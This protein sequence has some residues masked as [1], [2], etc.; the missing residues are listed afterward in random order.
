M[1]NAVRERSR[2]LEL[3]LDVLQTFGK[4]IPE[5]GAR[6]LS[7][8]LG[9]SP[10]VIERTL[11]T[12]E[13]R[14][15]LERSTSRI[16]YRLGPAVLPLAETYARLNQFSA[17]ALRIMRDIRDD[18]GETTCLHI[19]SGGQRLTLLQVESRQELRWVVD[20]GKRYPLHRG[21]SG[22]VLLAY[23]PS[24]MRDAVLYE[25]F[26]AEWAQRAEPKELLGSLENIRARGWSVTY[27]ER[28]PGG[29]GIAVPVFTSAY[30]QTACLSVYAPATRMNGECEEKFLQILLA[31]S[32]RL[33]DR[34]P[35]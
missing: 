23:L 9:A 7:R 4:D 18:I 26:G 5:A 33:S 11:A 34:Q 19:Y 17:V 27:G 35:E 2:A 29:V 20:M 12:L 30:A 13:A 1:A 22:K 16:K 21:A 15:Y 28:E 10:A 31:A 32:N 6:E 24:N 14:G 25:T 8:S 3:A